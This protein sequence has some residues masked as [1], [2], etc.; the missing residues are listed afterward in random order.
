MPRF[1]GAVETTRPSS[2]KGSAEGFE[3]EGPADKVL[4]F[5]VLFVYL[6]FDAFFEFSCASD[7]NSIIIVS[8]PTGSQPRVDRRAASMP[9]HL[10]QDEGEWSWIVGN[11][12]SLQAATFLQRSGFRNDDALCWSKLC[13]EHPRARRL[14]REPGLLGGFGPGGDARAERQACGDDC[15]QWLQKERCRTDVARSHETSLRGERL[16]ATGTSCSRILSFW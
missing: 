11:L 5:I 3:A 9:S 15:R 4:H 2:A 6:L 12:S 1:G 8:S 13:H 16:K 14:H 10:G 7:F